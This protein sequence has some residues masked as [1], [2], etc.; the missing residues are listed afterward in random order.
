MASATCLFGVILG[1]FPAKQEG[2]DAWLSG[3]RDRQWVVDLVRALRVPEYVGTP[4]SN[5]AAGPDAAAES[6]AAAEEK[7]ATS[8][9][10]SSA[11]RSLTSYGS[12]GQY[13]G[14]A[15]LACCR[16]ADIVKAS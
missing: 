12:S 10:V 11:R 5:D 14:Q 1:V 13:K 16:G 6:A 4:V 9:S 8:A 7:K 3:C 15:R 2:D